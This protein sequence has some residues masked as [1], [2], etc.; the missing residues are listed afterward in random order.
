MQPWE[1]RFQCSDSALRCAFESSVLLPFLVTGHS[2][3]HIMLWHRH[4]DPEK[5]VRVGAKGFGMRVFHGPR[6]REQ[7]ASVNRRHNQ[8]Q[9]L[10][11]ISAV[12]FELSRAQFLNTWLLI[13]T[14]GKPR[15]DNHL[16]KRIFHCTWILRSRPLRVLTNPCPG[17][18]ENLVGRNQINSYSREIYMVHFK[19]RPF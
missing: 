12:N 14:H 11:N 6:V 13:E 2:V 3:I 15:L 17:Q 5:R 4:C 16:Q 1:L 18:V 9:H 7:S 8:N 10:P 19:I